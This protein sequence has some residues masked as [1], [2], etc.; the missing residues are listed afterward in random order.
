MKNS[1]LVIL[2]CATLATSCSKRG[3]KNTTTT[4][5]TF[6]SA[7][8]NIDTATLKGNSG[9]YGGSGTIH[10]RIQFG[11]SADGTLVQSYNSDPY[12][13]VYQ[14]YKFTATSF[15]GG[16]AT[17]TL[18]EIPNGATPIPN[19]PTTTATL[20][21]YSNG[22]RSYYQLTISG[23]IATLQSTIYVDSI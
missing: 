19:A 22:A 11:L 1:I 18:T 13:G 21:I 3:T 7:F 12:T 9:Y 23:V 14:D 16:V 2:A 17:G 20:G 5:T 15:S 4:S 6:A 10:D 8:P